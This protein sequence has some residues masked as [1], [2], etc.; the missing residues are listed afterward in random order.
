HDVDLNQL[1]QQ[2]VELTRARWSDQP[3][4]RGIMVELKTVLA[5]GLPEI[6]GADSEIRD[7][8]TNLI[9]NAV[10]AMPQGGT[11][12]VRTSAREIGAPQG[13]SEHWVQLEV[14]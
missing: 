10:D 12:E 11:I 7:A 9:F 2:I 1:V 4:R 6:R 14:A 13:G 8:L 5:S 3:Q